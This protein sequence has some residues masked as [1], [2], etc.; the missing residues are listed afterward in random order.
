MRMPPYPET[1]TLKRNARNSVELAEKVN[2]YHE[3]IK[4]KK[5]IKLSIPTSL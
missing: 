4:R 2:R 1:E 5:N 3:G